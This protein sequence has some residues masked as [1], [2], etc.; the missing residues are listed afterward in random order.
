MPR[1]LRLAIRRAVVFYARAAHD[2]V[3]D[4]N[5]RTVG[6]LGQVWKYMI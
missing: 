6:F 1:K 2:F 3:Q 5:V 4:S